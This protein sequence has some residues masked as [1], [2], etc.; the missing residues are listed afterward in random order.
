MNSSD[1]GQVSV[2]VSEEPVPPA[3]DWSDKGAHDCEVDVTVECLYLLFTWKNILNGM[4]LI[5][6][7]FF[8]LQMIIHMLN[9]N[10]MGNENDSP[11]SFLNLE[12]SNCQGYK[13]YTL[14][15]IHAF[16]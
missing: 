13:D 4:D 12:S 3:A 2:P 6:L 7:L 10:D 1:V 15:K 8:P 9:V 11:W 16:P 5:Q 14:K